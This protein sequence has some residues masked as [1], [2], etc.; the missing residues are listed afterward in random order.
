MFKQYIFVVAFK[1]G[2]NMAI[3]KNL[4]WIQPGTP[5]ARNPDHMVRS[6]AILELADFRETFEIL[7]MKMSMCAKSARHCVANKVNVS[8]SSAQ[9]IGADGALISLML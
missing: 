7:G 3:N 4:H 6:R 5:Y 9:G 8:C 1:A 2:L